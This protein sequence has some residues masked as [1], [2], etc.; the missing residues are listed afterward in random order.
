MA[1]FELRVPALGEGII[2][3]VITKWLISEGDTIKPDQAAAEIATD[4]VDSEI[5]SPVEGT[6]LKLVYHEGDTAKIGSVIALIKTN[7]AEA[8]VGS[9]E[10]HPAA[11]I[12][13]QMAD[14][15][16]V[17]LKPSQNQEE[18]K[19]KIPRLVRHLARQ[20]G[21]ISEDFNRI[22]GTGSD[23]EVT[24]GDIQHYLLNRNGFNA[25]SHKGQNDR[26]TSVPL[27]DEGD[28]MIE[29]TRVR[30][31][32]AGNMVRSKQTA[33]HVTSFAEADVTGLVQWRDKQKEFFLKQEKIRLTYTPVFVQFVAAAL[34][35]FP[36]INSSIHQQSIILKNKINIGIATALP[37][38]NLIVPVIR[39]ADHEGLEGLAHKIADLAERARNNSLKPDEI[40]GGTFTITNIG[41]YTSLTGT[42]II[43]QPESA[44][45]AIGSIVKKPWAVKTPEGYGISVRDIVMLSLT[46]DHRII[47]GALAGKFLGH[48]VNQLERFGLEQVCNK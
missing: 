42:P 40:K 45:L 38:G 7:G 41:S 33:P 6:V 18:A 44:I 48:I 24:A 15:D 35:E 10:T 43:N 46:Y 19:S 22:H 17:S 4:K 16:A 39:N 3:A 23:G 30:K 28:E 5:P 14:E 9:E 8:A 36:F 11:L 27:L 21:L 1:N 32:I 2:E 26:T 34:R 13:N 25:P 20:R 31:I 47:D 37:D 29:M 12:V